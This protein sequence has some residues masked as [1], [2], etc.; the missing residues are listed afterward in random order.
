M[1]KEQL[2]AYQLWQRR[3]TVV[4]PGTREVRKL[5][6]RN[7]TVKK[8]PLRPD[9]EVRFC[10]SFTGR[11]IDSLAFASRDGR[12]VLDGITLFLPAGLSNLNRGA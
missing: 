8:R 5:P 7:C 9:D 2:S 4:D 11:T 6:I 1:S 12:V 3:I 10:R